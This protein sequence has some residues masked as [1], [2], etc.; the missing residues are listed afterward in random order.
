MGAYFASMR[1][2]LV[3]PLLAALCFAGTA[4]AGCA[5]I[6][7]STF[8][9]YDQNFD[10][11]A[12]SGSSS[13]VP[14]GWSIYDGDGLMIAD[15]GS[16]GGAGLYSYGTAGSSWRALGSVASAAMAPMFGVCLKNATGGNLTSIWIR[17]GG[18]QWHVGATGRS[19][20][21]DF[22]F[23]TDATSLQTGHWT[24]VDALDVN[25]IATGAPVGRINGSLPQYQ[26]SIGA[27]LPAGITI[28]AGATFWLRWKDFDAAGND[29]GLA[30]DNVHVGA[31]SDFEPPPVISLQGVSVDEGNSGT[32][33]A[34]ALA[35][36]NKAAPA[37]GVAFSVKVYGGSAKSGVDYAPSG[38]LQGTI[39][40]G[41]T[42]APL[43]FTV[44][45][46]QDYEADEYALIDVVS[47]TGATPGTANQSVKLTIRNDDPK[48]YLIDEI[49]WRDM[50]GDGPQHIGQRLPVGG[51]VTA[52]VENGFFMQTP[53]GQDDGF[54]QS[55]SGI[56]VDTGGAPPSSAAVGNRVVVTGTVQ[57]FVPPDDPGSPE[58]TQLGASPAITVVSSGNPLPAP[59]ALQIDPTDTNW[60]AYLQLEPYEGMRVTPGT[61]VVTGP[62]QG[63]VTERTST[64]ASNGVFFATKVDPSRGIP[65]REQGIEQP[66]PNPSG[67]ESLPLPI[68]DGNPEVIAVDSDAQGGSQLNLMTGTTVTGLQGVLDYR[69]RRYTLLRDPTAPITMTSVSPLKY[70]PNPPAN[71]FTVASFNLDRFYDPANDPG[72]DEPVLT[73]DAFNA[74]VAK[75]SLAVRNALHLPDILGLQDVENS[76]ALF[77]IG[78]KINN[79]EVAAGHPNPAYKP[80]LLEGSATDGLDVALLVKTAAGA[81]GRPRVQVRSV[82][83]IGKSATFFD[84]GLGHNAVLFDRPPLMLDATVDID[85]SGYPLTVINAQLRDRE[86]IASEAASGLTTLGDRVRQKRLQQ[87][88]YIANYIQQ[89][90]VADPT[91]KIVLLG[92]FD[93]PAVNDGYVDVLAVFHEAPIDERTAVPNDGAHILNPTLY[94]PLGSTEGYND[95]DR[96]SRQQTDHILINAALSAGGGTRMDYARIDAD[97]PETRRNDT[98]ALRVSS[99]DPVVLYVTPDSF[100][101]LSA[102]VTATPAAVK[103]GQAMTFTAKVRNLG[104][105]TAS[106]VGAGFAFDAELPDLAIT[107]SDPL[108]DCEVPQIAAGSTTIACV[109]SQVGSGGTAT[110]TVTASAPAG[111]AG[112]QVHLAITADSA[113]VD[114]VPGNNQ[115]S[116]SVNVTP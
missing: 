81:S 49:Q 102:S 20:R 42:S 12:S 22:Q 74:R 98:T 3:L 75:L 36:L 69:N 39:P 6:P 91:R 30:V 99:H 95:L 113:N 105:D 31:T 76:A 73:I 19:D 34:V 93:A 103:A 27:D 70:A 97:F 48:T 88:Q 29:D 38:T 104:P 53:D 52:R 92:D 50:F 108:Q 71:G 83:Q 107:S 60:T 7:W 9:A 79:D 4:H 62:T 1:G 13:Q 106:F 66:D 56:F 24:D 84:P 2:G 18:Q 61:V 43:N 32:K 67:S 94:T 110:F 37:G 82:V 14:V 5:E 8:I 51:V 87:V 96:G 21:L 46:D 58:R 100:A 77:S 80:Y 55:S 17:Y 89:L 45:G 68:W 64:A 72:R 78:V 35:K 23:S 40:A 112:G 59:V 44:Y 47:A 63:V 41:K 16:H 26:L 85:G 109:F 33:T 115:A 25:T 114:P 86:D 116:T 90:Q 15:D 65:Y 10:S 11:L 54:W 111:K 28:P 57:S 101:D